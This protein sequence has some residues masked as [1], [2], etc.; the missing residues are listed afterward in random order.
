MEKELE[1]DGAGEGRE[2]ERERERERAVERMSLPTD[3][4]HSCDVPKGTIENQIGSHSAKKNVKENVTQGR[5]S[6]LG[7]HSKPRLT[8]LSI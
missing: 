8:E 4:V 3:K 6:L 2:R 1:R 7:G 5:N